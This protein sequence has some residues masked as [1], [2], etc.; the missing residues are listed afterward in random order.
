M[1]SLS[2]VFVVA[3]FI[4]M[5]MK[6]IFAQEITSKSPVY[7]EVIST[8]DKSINLILGLYP[9]TYQYNSSSDYSYMTLRILNQ[10]AT[11]FE[12]AD[13]KI[14]IML[15]DNT[16]FYNYKTQASSGNFNC[17]YTVEAGASNDQK[18]CFSKK[19]NYS[20]IA[21]AWISFGDDK[22]FNLV[23]YNGTN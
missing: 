22:F 20:D 6:Q 4:L 12:W 16:M 14:Y 18:V 1:K 21:K 13:Y 3:A 7:M 5:P 17:K 11:S 2:Y 10:A 23:F 15:N 8:P 19:F 9:E